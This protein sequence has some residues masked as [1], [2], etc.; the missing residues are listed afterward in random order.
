[1]ATSWFLSKASE[2]DLLFQGHLEPVS[3]S[4]THTLGY[5]IT[6]SLNVV[7]LSYSEGRGILA[8][9]WF[10]SKASDLNLLFQCHSAPVSPYRN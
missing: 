3:P 5:A 10:L 1:M 2:L 4:V 7:E 9:S 8:T 6:S